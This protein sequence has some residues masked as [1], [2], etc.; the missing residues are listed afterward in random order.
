MPER[1][2]GEAGFAHLVEAL[3]SSDGVTLGS[4]RRGFGS[5]ALRVDGRIFAMLRGGRLV[6]KLPRERVAALVASGDGSPF[7]AGKGRPMKE[8]ILLEPG[9]D[10][11]WL[12]LAKEALAFVAGHPT[13]ARRG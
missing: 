5:D 13:S 1:S 10:Q 8:W 12:S 7:D 4:G 11:R 6:L 3:R 2:A 9:A